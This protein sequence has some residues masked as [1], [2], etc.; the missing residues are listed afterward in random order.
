MAEHVDHRA[1]ETLLQDH[2]SI[3]TE[4]V[5]VGAAGTCTPSEEVMT[6]FS[7]LQNTFETEQ[8]IREVHTY[9]N[10]FII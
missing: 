6:L 5:S 1:R 8:D 4:S 10:V 9:S 2:G 3:T 7:S